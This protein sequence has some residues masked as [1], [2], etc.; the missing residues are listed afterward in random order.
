MQVTVATKR[1]PPRTVVK[2]VPY[3]PTD[4]ELAQL[5]RELEQ[6]RAQAGQTETVTQIVVPDVTG[7]PVEQAEQVIRSVGLT[8]SAT[9]AGTVQTQTPAAGNALTAGQ[10]VTLTG[11]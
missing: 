3:V 1:A 7:L 10:S 8:A 11:G 6:A 9:G 4:S 2:E 5:R